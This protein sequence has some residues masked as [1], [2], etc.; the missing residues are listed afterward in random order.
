MKIYLALPVLNKIIFKTFSEKPYTSASLLYS[1]NRVYIPSTKT[2]R[3][4][5][6]EKNKLQQLLEQ[7]QSIQGKLD[8]MLDS[9]A[10]TFQHE[11]ALKR[12]IV[13]IKH[14]EWLIE[15][16]L[17]WVSHL[18]NNLKPSLV[19]ELDLQNL[20]TYKLI[21]QWRT[22]YFLPFQKTTSIPV[23]FVT[24]ELSADADKEFFADTSVKFVGIG[25]ASGGWSIKD[26]HN[27]VWY[28]TKIGKP[29]HGFASIVV[30]LLKQ[31]PFYSVDSM[32][33]S[34]SAHFGAV[35][36]FNPERGTIQ[37][38]T[39]GYK[40]PPKEAIKKLSKIK[41]FSSKTRLLSYALG[42]R[43]FIDK[44]IDK[45]TIA[46]QTSLKAYLQLQEWYS[47]YWT[48]RGIVWQQTNNLN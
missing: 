40:I 33:W 39:V 46:L 35:H 41:T 26:I 32:S 23:V 12:K 5:K 4:N 48:R 18:P 36:F 3:T 19:V 44:Q 31:V 10:Y 25:A 2:T 34:Y 1:A 8:W 30:P 28:Y 15:N 29:V 47:A 7:V 9:G 13:P 45:S 27:F 37:S 20:Y 21:E 43:R 42:P 11:Y 24:H 17:D 16:Y 14:L 38:V 6:N 22:K